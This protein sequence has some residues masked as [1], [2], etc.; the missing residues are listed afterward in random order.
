MYGAVTAILPKYHQSQSL[1]VSA[2][3]HRLLSESTLGGRYARK[4]LESGTVVA[5]VVVAVEN[6]D[7]GL[8]DWRTSRGQEGTHR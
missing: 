2:F 4:L 1:S 5:L 3:P 8:V 6:G 7:G